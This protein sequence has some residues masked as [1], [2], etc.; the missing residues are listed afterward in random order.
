MHRNDAGATG[1]VLPPLDG[2][3][4]AGVYI[5]ADDPARQGR[6]RTVLSNPRLIGVDTM[7]CYLDTAARSF[8]AV[9]A[10]AQIAFATM[11]EGRVLTGE[12][13]GSAIARALFALDVKIVVLKDGAAGAVLYRAGRAIYVP[14]PPVSAVDPTGAG[15]AF[16][17]TFMASLAGLDR[18][19]DDALRMAGLRGAAAASITVEGFGTLALARATRADIEMRARE[20]GQLRR[21]A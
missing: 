20:I 15:D 1:G 16:A 19:D 6:I 3:D 4:G 7:P 5:G 2:I 21:S 10:G 17:G 14:A 9:L 12:R 13:E 8:Q 18:I 11:E